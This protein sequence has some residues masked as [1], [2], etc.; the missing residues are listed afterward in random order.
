[1]PSRLNYQPAFA[2]V[3]LDKATVS[4]LGKI[5]CWDLW[6]LF[7][8]KIQSLYPGLKILIN[9]KSLVESLPSHEPLS[10]KF[11]HLNSELSEL[12]FLAEI[13]A[14]LPTS[15][16]QDPD[17]DEVCFLYFNGI[18]PL[19][20]LELTKESIERHKK[21]FSQYSYSE[22]LPEGLVPK[23]LTREFLSS[24][25]D[26]L[27]TDVHAFFLKNINQYD[28]DIFF[29]P[30]DLRQ[31]RL[32]FRI[33]N[34]RSYSLV[35]KYLENSK[36]NSPP[37]QVNYE[38]ILPLL[39]K[40]PAWFR[41]FPSYIEWEIIQACEFKCTFCPRQDLDLSQD[42]TQVSLQEATKFIS[43]WSTQINSDFT[44]ALGGNGEPFLHPHWKEIFE[45]ILVIPQL[46]ELIVETALY[47]HFSEL[48]SWLSNRSPQE[49]A[50]LSF[51][52]NFTTLKAEKYTKLYGQNMHLEILENIK[53][54][55]S[56]LP[57]KSI[58]VQ[59][60][61]MLD[62]KEEIEE[63]FNFFEKLGIN[64]ILQKYNSFAGKLKEKRVSD[65]TPI[66]REFC[67]HLTRDLYVN[68]DGS[69][70]ICKQSTKQNLGNLKTES[71]SDLWK[72]GE[73]YFSKSFLRK[74]TEIPAPCLQCDEWYTF[75]A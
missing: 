25:P 28:V 33:S 54:L 42:G 41:E 24:L 38:D 37:Y 75:N 17:W 68:S 36:N 14:K 6:N 29:V 8:D 23:V 12:E 67:W 31:Y 51:I 60:I 7:S 39:E 20:D 52:V 64:V 70:A 46:N 21:Y 71:F 57:P 48:K 73:D 22:N 1:M 55:K 43:D 13:G 9:S 10:D 32:D 49:L 58:N 11:E 45:R 50:K 19:L 56:I 5:Q 30:P 35:Q 69:V 53:S 65:L 40:N 34:F 4:F 47:S 72:K 26:S 18:C 2:V 62:V 63:Y 44:I 74:H 27:G 61:K 59:M 3:F 16:F 66:R 15:Q